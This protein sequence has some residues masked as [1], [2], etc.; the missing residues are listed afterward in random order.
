MKSICGGHI[1][2]EA[3][4]CFNRGNVALLPQDPSALS[5]DLPLMPSNLHGTVCV[6]FTGGSFCPSVE[7]LQ[8][9]PPVLV[10]KSRVKCIIEWLMSNNEWY[11]KNG[12]SFSAENLVALVHSSNNSVV[13]QGIE[14][15]HLQ[16]E[17]GA[18]DSGGDVDW[19]ALAT[20]LV[21]KTVTYTDGD[22]SELSHHTM[23][24]AALTHAL[25][26]KSFLPSHT[27]SELMNENLPGILSTVFLH[28]D[29]WGIGGFNHPAHQ[30]D[31]H[32][33]FQ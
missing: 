19:S 1:P 26:R 24:V 7:A 13:L 33:S 12:I 28:L 25:N 9:F 16:D 5:N 30:P 18:S 14:I 17:D 31:Q 32:I 8:R 6:V 21:T 11:M 29:P 10:S 23:K 20:D 4:Q 2:E 27:G 3:S 15:T 22:R